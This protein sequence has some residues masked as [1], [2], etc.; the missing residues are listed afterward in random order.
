MRIYYHH[1]L[2]FHYR[3]A[4]TIQVVQDYKN[5]ARLGHEV[6]LFGTYEDPEALKEIQ[7]DIQG[8]PVHLTVRRGHSAWNRGWLRFRFLL[9]I[10]ADRRPKLVVARNYNK[11]HELARLRCLCGPTWILME[12]HEDALPYLC[13]PQNTERERKR[14]EALFQRIDALILTNHSQTEILAREFLQLPKS[15]VLPNS[16]DIESFSPAKPVQTA[17]FVLTYTGQF[18]HWK[19]VELL[20]QALT[21]LDPCY[22]LRLAGG[23]GDAASR[24]WVEKLTRNYDLEGRVDF[25]GFVPRG[26]LVS[27]VLDGSSALLLPLGDNVESRYLTSPMKLFEY[28]ATSIPV[29]AVDYPSVRLITGTD[30]VYLSPNEPRAFAEAIRTAVTKPDPR[31]I[32]AMHETVRQYDEQARAKRFDAYIRELAS[33]PN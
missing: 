8:L 5:L 32:E 3:S 4:Q 25:R 12:R 11:T 30:T 17:P 13:K 18:T 1:P 23:K 10:L 6:H 21:Y 14:F 29:V 24:Q 19:N 33:S 22:Q 9:K 15:I 16:V 31:R 7:D 27:E 28:M 2:Q 26:S 20:F